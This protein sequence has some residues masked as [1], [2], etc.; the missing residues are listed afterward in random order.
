MEGVLRGSGVGLLNSGNFPKNTLVFQKS[1]LE[2][3]Q[4]QGV[5]SRE[6]GILQPGFLEKPGHLGTSQEAEGKLA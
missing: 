2:D 1:W 5:V 6:S 3:S 4:N